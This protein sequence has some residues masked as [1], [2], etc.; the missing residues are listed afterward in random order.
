MPKATGP[1][2]SQ[3]QNR[4]FQAAAASAT[5]AKKAGISQKVAKKMVAEQHGHPVGGLPQKVKKRK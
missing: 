4:L 2:R 3:A 5:V 1:F